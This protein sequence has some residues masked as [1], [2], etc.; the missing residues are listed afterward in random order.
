MR[1]IV[2][3]LGEMLLASAILAAPAPRP[4]GSDWGKLSDPD[5]N[6]KFIRGRDSLTIEMPGA[7]H[8]FDLRR[9]RLNAP[10]LLRE[11][12]GDFVMQ[13]RV[14]IDCRPSA[15][16]TVTGQPPSVSG[17]FLIV[18]PANA[19]IRLEYGVRS[20]GPGTKGYIALKERDVLGGQMNCVGDER[21]KGWPLGAKAENAY[22]RLERRGHI[23]YFSLG[24][25][26]EK[27]TS[28]TGHL[29]KEIPAKL[30]IGLAAYST[31]SEPSKARFDE[32]KLTQGEKADHGPQPLG[33]DWD[34]PLDPDKDCKFLRDRDSLTI[35]M[36]GSDHDFDIRRGRLNAPRLLREIEGD[37]V[38]RVRVRLE[39]SPTSESTIVG[40]PTSAS[41]GFLIV[42]S[43][44]ACIRLEY[45]I[46]PRWVKAKGYAALIDCQPPARKGQIDGKW[47]ERWKHWPLT[48]KAEHAYLRLERRGKVLY[49]AI[50]P[51]G[52]K[53]EPLI[54]SYWY[55]DLPEKLKVGLAAFSTSTKPSKARFDEFKL[56]QGKKQGR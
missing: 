11:I 44:N 6:C 39:C 30:K 18:L 25:D 36:P 40:E 34:K 14:R 43:E 41:G 50:S 12:E 26:G 52:D 54:G 45:G 37:F 8:D 55:E 17:G 56:T 13:V 27:W 49:P 28:L 24:P 53:W 35:E 7:D 33:E 48:A 9:D 46:R 29:T 32:F 47:D 20:Q 5:K 10:C 31:L 21:W 16:S 51:D 23:L 15:E 22:L 2:A 19:C 4:F 3:V 42:L 1:S 38:M